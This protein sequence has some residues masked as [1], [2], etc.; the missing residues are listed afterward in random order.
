M[1]DDETRSAVSVL[2]EEYGTVLFDYCHT[3]LS[4][5]LAARAAAGALLAAHLD[6]ARLKDGSRRTAWLYALARVHRSATALD[7]PASTGSWHRP[8]PMGDMLAPALATLES[9]HRELLDLSLRHRLGHVDIALIFDAGAVEVEAV[10]AEGAAR[11][12]RWFAAVSAAGAPGGCAVMAELLGRW[13]GGP[14]RQGRTRIGGHLDA[15]AAC[16]AVPAT[17]PA[18]ALLS[19]HRMVG[20]PGALADWLP[21]RRAPL[22][23]RADGFPVQARSLADATITAPMAALSGLDPANTAKSRDRVYTTSASRD[24]GSGSGDSGPGRPSS[25]FGPSAS[26]AFGSGVSGGSP[27]SPVD[28]V[29]PVGTAAGAGSWP[30]AGAAA[31]GQD[32]P[33]VPRALP[34]YT[35]APARRDDERHSPAARKDA[36]SQA[37]TPPDGTPH[38]DASGGGPPRGGTPGGGTPHGRAPHGGAPGDGEPGGGGS[39]KAP[40]SGRKGGKAGE[41]RSW[42]R[43]G[44][45]WEEFWRNRPDESNPEARLSVRSVA[46]VGVLVGAGVLVAGLAWTG[47]HT[48]VQPARVAGAA[49][50]Q[51]LPVP[52]ESVIEVPPGATVPEQPPPSARRPE[53]PRDRARPPTTAPVRAER[54]DDPLRSPTKAPTKDSAKDPAKDPTKAP[55]KD[56][57]KGP[58]KAPTKAP[59]K[60]PNKAPATREPTRTPERAQQRTPTAEPTRERQQALAK[61]PP[62]PKPP[63]PT[64]RLSSSSASLGSGRSGSLSLDCTGSCQITSASGSNGISV[65][66]S[67]YSVSAP[68]SRPGCPGPDSTESGTISVSWSGTTTGNGTTTEGT[69]TGGGTLTMS[70]SWTVARDKGT[71]VPDMNGGGYWSNCGPNSSG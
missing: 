25:R 6:R 26:P 29:H 71:Y 4:P 68:T 13:L 5:E 37:G 38:G 57:A 66:G 70:V 58:A 55:V 24:I 32:P 1:L 39:R 35:P 54:P 43:H 48:Q 52:T 49:I 22:A 34:L 21:D 19:G 59:T 23:W 2:S 3:E 9:Q 60:A 45:Q 53:D 36:T 46:R 64:A 69:A 11:L 67:S 16:Q 63:P 61:P 62:L 27:A 41:F 47:M 10:L 40:R 44:G 56:P 31:S 8:G 51:P 15:C 7:H 28:A 17:L 20:V 65:S 18:E 42:E 12:E 50:P 14:S 30:E 33:S